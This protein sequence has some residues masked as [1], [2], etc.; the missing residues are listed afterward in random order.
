[1]SP[2]HQ[3]KVSEMRGKVIRTLEEPTHQRVKGKE[4]KMA[5]DE[6]VVKEAHGSQ[7]G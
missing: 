2:Y 5:W 1:M 4:V 7:G 6:S 3:K